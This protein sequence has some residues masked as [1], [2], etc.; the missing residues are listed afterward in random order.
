MKRMVLAGLL[1]ALA[2]LGALAY[3][4]LENRRDPVV[5]GYV[6]C[7]TGKF[8]ALSGSG[9]DGAVLAVEHVNARGGVAGRR[10]ELVVVDDGFNPETAGEAV[11]SLHAMGASAVIGPFASA[12]AQPMLDAATRA[13]ALLVSPTVATDD[14]TGKDDLFIRLIPTTASVSFALGKHMAQARGLGAAVALADRAYQSGNSGEF[15]IVV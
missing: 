2:A 4:R 14:L 11:K 3:L 1:L 10:L 13:G 9:R 7:L 5:L 6:S 15:E 12:M 8:S